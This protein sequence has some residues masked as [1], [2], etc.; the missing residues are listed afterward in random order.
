MRPHRVAAVAVLVLLA[1]AL[2]GVFRPEAAEGVE[3]G[4]QTIVVNGTGNLLVTP[5]RA[6]LSFGVESR[7]RTA[8][9]ALAANGIEMRRVLE[10]LR[11]V[12]ID[13]T[14][15]HTEYVSL[16]PAY[17]S[18]GREIVAYVASNTAG[19]QVELREAGAVVDAAVE[20]GANHVYGPTMSRSDESDQYRRA[21][22]AALGDAR[23]KAEALA[24]AGGFS[25]GPIISVA[26]TGFAPPPE[27]F[28]AAERAGGVAD[29]TPIEPGR[30]ELLATVTV[31]FALA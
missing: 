7:G 13:E 14:K 23:R 10:A 19:A 1:A 3:A 6:D 20:A 26:E 29:A 8:R 16:M 22:R 28:A 30:S 5:D 25:V 18:D 27:P 21:L 11:E 2:A 31:T 4:G 15:L 9:E 17:D 12:G 24:A